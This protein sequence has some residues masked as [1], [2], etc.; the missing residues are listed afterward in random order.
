MNKVRVIERSVRCQALGWA[1]VLPVLGVIP[2]VIAIVLYPQATA[3]AGADWNPAESYARRG[4][5][6]AW[7]GLGLSAVLVAVGGAVLISLAFR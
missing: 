2:A 5:V 7:T 3:E 4:L 6:L 1:G